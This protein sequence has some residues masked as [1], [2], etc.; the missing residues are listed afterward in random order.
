MPGGRPL[1]KTTVP[2]AVR[3]N[4]RASSAELRNPIFPGLWTYVGD[5]LGIGLTTIPDF[6]NGW[7]Y[8]GTSYVGFRHGID[9]ETE[10]VGTLDTSNAASGTVAFTLPGPYRPLKEFSFITDLDL[11]GGDFDG[12]RVVVATNGEVTVYFP[13]TA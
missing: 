6:E 12:A 13:L 7:T 5:P 11:G 9:G 4:T 3:E 10:F 1:K 8:L 2:S